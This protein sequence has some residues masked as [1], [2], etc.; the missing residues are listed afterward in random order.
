ML[1]QL[2]GALDYSHRANVIHRD[3]KPGNIFVRADGTPVLLD[4]GAARLALGERTQSA[5]NAT[6]AGFISMYLSTAFTTRSMSLLSPLL[7]C[8]QILAF[9]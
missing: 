6:G 8:T 1:G 9:L 5:F 2:A 3:I 7:S 4:F